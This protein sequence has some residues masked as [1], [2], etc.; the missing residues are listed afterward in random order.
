[1]Q[2]LSN[3]FTL[4]NIAFILKYYYFC[5]GKYKQHTN[6]V[7]FLFM[8]RMQNLLHKIETTFAQK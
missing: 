6:K 1:M 2:I 3:T 8:F 4:K 5:S 7:I